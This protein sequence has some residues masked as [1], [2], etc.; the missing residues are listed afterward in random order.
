M[1]E[2]TTLNDISNQLW[3][4]FYAVCAVGGII[5]GA[6]ISSSGG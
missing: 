6:I 1:K 4:I 3:I 2:E 5:T